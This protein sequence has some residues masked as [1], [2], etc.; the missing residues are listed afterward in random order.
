[1]KNLFRILIAIL[2]FSFSAC[3]ERI[4]VSRDGT[5]F[6]GE[7]TGKKFIAWGFNY[8]HNHKNE[9]IEE[10][11]ADDWKTLA[12]DFREMKALGANL[13]RIHLQTTGIMTNRDRADPVALKHLAR[14]VKLAEETKLYLDITGLACY[15]PKKVPKWYNDLSESDRWDVQA[16]F[17]EAVA[18]TCAGSSAVFCYDLMNEP[19]LPGKKK[20]TEWLTGKLGGFTFVQRISLDLAGRTRQ[21]VAKEWVDKLVTSIRK[22]DKKTLLTVGVIPWAYAFFPNVKKPLFYSDGVDEKLDFVSV[23]FY[24]KKNDVANALK[25]LACYEVGKPI[26]IEETYTLGCGI[27]DFNAFVDESRKL[28][29]G[30]VAHYFGRTIDEYQKQKGTI[31]DAIHKEFLIYF[32]KKTPEILTGVKPDG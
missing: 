4:R 18:K 20:K 21:R 7:T 6:V 32:K 12:G 11:W 23:H 1:M 30:W 10:F 25:A 29:D 17:W 16:R 9:L 5:H 19:V 28:A 27:R 22:H 26:L 31:A 13:V 15:K 8:T 3:G 2:L 24:P 14:L